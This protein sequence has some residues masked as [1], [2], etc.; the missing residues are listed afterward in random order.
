MMVMSTG[1][2]VRVGER[3]TGD[4][5]KLRSELYMA[6]HAHHTKY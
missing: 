1:A 2:G 6:V 4:F 5:G 3:Y